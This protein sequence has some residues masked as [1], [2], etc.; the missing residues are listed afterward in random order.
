MRLWGW[1]PHDG[2]GALIRRDTRE[3]VSLSL[4]WAH[5]KKAARKSALGRSWTRRPLDLGLPACRT[6]RRKCLL[7]KPLCLWYLLEQPEH[8]KKNPNSRCRE[9][10]APSE[11]L[12]G[13][14]PH[15]LLILVVACNPWYSS[16]RSCVTPVSASVANGILPSVSLHQSCWIRA[17]PMTLS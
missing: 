6:V 12:G 4:I 14:L 8:T 1:G 16:A 11:T 3:V 7:C 5:S 17:H 15:L 2:I 13:T 10:Q 9:G